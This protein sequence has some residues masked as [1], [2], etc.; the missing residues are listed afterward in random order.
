[1]ST[2][3][4]AIKSISQK[5]ELQSA[6]SQAS[7][8]EKAV[9]IAVIYG[10]DSVLKYQEQYPELFNKFIP[11]RVPK[12]SCL[13]R[14]ISN[15]V[16]SFSSSVVL[17][18]PFFSSHLSLPVKAGE[19]VWV[20]FDRE[21]KTVGYWISRVHG[22]EY[23]EDLNFSHYD[24]I[25]TSQRKENDKPGTIE[26]ASG[27]KP[28]PP[29]DFP[30]LSLSQKG[31]VNEYEKI[32]STSLEPIALEPVPRYTK[33]PGDFAI[34]GSNNS[35][36][37]FGTERFWKKED[38][39]TTA[40]PLAKI[41]PKEYSGII[42]I[43]AGRSRTVFSGSAGRTSPEIFENTRKYKEIVKDPRN[44]KTLLKSEGD[45]DFYSDA[46]RIYVSINT[47]IDEAFSLTDFT[48]ILPNESELREPSVGASIALKSDHVRIISRKDDDLTINGTIKIIKE[49][50]ISND[51][52]GCSISLL[53]DGIVHVAASKIYL[54]LSTSQGGDS[55][56]DEEVAGEGQ[57]YVK[58]QE[59]NSILTSMFDLINELADAMS[60][61]APPGYAA[62]CPTLLG[63]GVSVLGKISGEKQKIPT[64]KSSRIFGE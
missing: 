58:Y 47:S 61:N 57:P 32:L 51:G 63:A 46:S 23:T 41:N 42:D 1:M 3:N 6:T 27:G 21:I 22:D 49:G 52:D 38:D 4:S 31:E 15:N 12:N 25:Y 33:R 50:E 5:S 45:P 9:V 10:Y 2:I 7:S 26:K 34:H 43:V 62:P 19:T 37:L 13:V 20:I 40:E 35:M 28:S 59:L 24:R 14:R 17:A 56:R 60:K 64:L 29:E 36:I 54:G 55:K 16:D 48:P 11:E 8:F 53:E 39:P 30:N 18:Y 44:G